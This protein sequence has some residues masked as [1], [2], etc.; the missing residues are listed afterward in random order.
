MGDDPT[1]ADPELSTF[2]ANT[3]I[4]EMHDYAMKDMAPHYRGN[5]I[6]VPMG[7]DFS[8]ANAHIN[9]LSMDRLIAYYNSHITDSTLL[10][11]TPGEYLDALIS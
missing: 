10:Y 8:Y 3:K 7:C 11:S 6:L 9:F 2:N 5:H 1:V 4:M